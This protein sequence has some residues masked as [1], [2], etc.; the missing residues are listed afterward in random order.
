MEVKMRKYLLI[1]LGLLTLG[2]AGCF[3]TGGGL[4]AV[5]RTDPN[6]PRGPWP[7]TLTFSGIHST[8]EIEQYL[9]SF[10]DGTTAAGAE[11]EHTYSSPGEYTAYL[12]VVAPG[13]S[14]HQAS[15]KVEVRSQ[16]PVAA[17][18]VWR[19][20]KGATIR[21]DASDSY[22]PDGQI[23]W[24]HWT[25]GDGLMEVTENPVVEHTY[26]GDGVYT[27]TLVVEDDYGDFSVPAK[28]DVVIS[29]SCSGCG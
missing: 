7:L 26:P 6:P 27:V 22:D 10:G 15:V 1:L 11:V 28:Q 12:T 18:E 5:I 21:F 17:F 2:L 24:Y 25:F 20:G 3:P 13:G 8:G 19:T 16:T 4:R 14:S 9:W 29:G 23:A